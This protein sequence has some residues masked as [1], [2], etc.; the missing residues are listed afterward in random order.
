MKKMTKEKSG[1]WKSKK[2]H[3]KHKHP[4]IWKPQVN[5]TEC[6]VR[7]IVYD[8]VPT[9]GPDYWDIGYTYTFAD[10]YRGVVDFLVLTQ[11]KIARMPLDYIPGFRQKAISNFGGLNDEQLAIV[12]ETL[13]AFLEVYLESQAVLQSVYEK[14][15]DQSKTN[16]KNNGLSIQQASLTSLRQRRTQMIQDGTVM[17]DHIQFRGFEAAVDTGI[18]NT[19]LPATREADNALILYMRYIENNS[20]RLTGLQL[21]RL[22]LI[23]N[24]LK[25]TIPKSVTPEQCTELK[26]IIDDLLKPYFESATPSIP[27]DSQDPQ[28]TNNFRTHIFTRDLELETLSSQMLLDAYGDAVKQQDAIKKTTTIPELIAV[29]RQIIYQARKQNDDIETRSIVGNLTNSY[30]ASINLKVE[31]KYTVAFAASDYSY[32]H[33]QEFAKFSKQDQD[34]VMETLLNYLPIDVVLSDR[35]QMEDYIQTEALESNK[36][37]KR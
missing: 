10:K 2:P 4:S 6:P 36:K 31:A 9:Y 19:R 18:H 13:T 23:S 12:E 21:D 35:K 37:Y 25:M 17:F 24:S 33:G 11:D 14:A 29:R 3:W 15:I 7:P 1:N 16:M 26:A 30:I 8:R 32:D 34:K 28:D 22:Q 20:D 5:N 27:W